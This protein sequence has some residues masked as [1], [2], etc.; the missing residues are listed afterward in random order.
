MVRRRRFLF[1][2][3]WCGGTVC[4]RFEGEGGD[5]GGGAQ[6]HWLDTNTD[7]AAFKEGDSRKALQDYKTPGDVAKALIEAKREIRTTFRVPQSLEGLQE[8]EV[9]KITDRLKGL[10]KPEHLRRITGAPDKPEAYQLDR[11]QQIPEGYTYDEDTEKGFRTLCHELGI[12][13]EAA[14]KLHAYGIERDLARHTRETKELDDVWQGVENARIKKVGGKEAWDKEKGL[15]KRFF[16]EW[17]PKAGYKHEDIVAGLLEIKNAGMLT[18]LIGTLAHFMGI[19]M[20]EGVTNLGG[21][22]GKGEGKIDVNARWPRSAN[23]MQG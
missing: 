20:P 4:A 19:A 21:I 10:L 9:T 6:A 18:P 16:S 22:G 11:P 8:G 14:K 1:T 15:I 13:V 5:G 23:V 2:S 3:P 12:P 7:F 17:A